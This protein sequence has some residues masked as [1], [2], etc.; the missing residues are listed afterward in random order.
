YG[1]RK[2]Y[3]WAKILIEKHLI[4]FFGGKSLAL[5]Q[6]SLIRDYQQERLK[7]VSGSSVN[8]E[9][10]VLSK[11][12]TLAVRDSLLQDNRVRLVDKLPEPEGRTFYL[13][14]EQAGKL[15]DACPD[16][17]PHVHRLVTVLLETGARVG[18]VLALR[19][20][21]IDFDTH[22]IR[23]DSRTTKA[24]RERFIP[25]TEEVEA[26]L[27]QAHSERLKSPAAREWVFT[28]G[29]RHL[30]SCRRAFY[31]AMGQAGSERPKGTGFHLTRHS[32][33]TW[34]MASEG[35]R[36]KLQKILGHASVKMTE[37]YIHAGAEYLDTA[38]QH[39]GRSAII[40]QVKNERGHTGG[41]TAHEQQS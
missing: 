9:V 6:P 16:D 11:I 33:A 35:R 7:K 12:M 26:V 38:R 15:L 24:S 32:A 14:A 17:F 1:G 30:K 5:I 19:W 3:R 28:Y 41:H 13:T 34:Y 29:G 4:P 20:E 8:R 37:R 25:M 22:R 18:E 31:T 36:D 10:A 39:L 21:N 2:C 27:R 40:R 23:F